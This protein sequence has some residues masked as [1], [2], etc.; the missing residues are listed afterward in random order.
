MIR[1]RNRFFEKGSEFIAMLVSRREAL[2]QGSSLFEDGVRNLEARDTQRKKSELVMKLHRSS[3]W[4]TRIVETTAR[5][6]KDW[7]TNEAPHTSDTLERISRRVEAESI[8]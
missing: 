8:F 6:T 7:A 5:G 2:V 3:S 1:D 4:Q